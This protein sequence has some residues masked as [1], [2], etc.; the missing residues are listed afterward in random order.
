MFDLMNGISKEVV[1]N[2]SIISLRIFQFWIK[3]FTEIEIDGLMRL[4]HIHKANR[5]PSKWSKI[6]FG[7][8]D[9]IPNNLF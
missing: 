9:A 3:R 7:S 4:C 6:I 2:K 5:I 1:I 8:S